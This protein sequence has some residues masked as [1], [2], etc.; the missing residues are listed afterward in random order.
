MFLA[1]DINKS[2]IRDQSDLCGQKIY[3][4]GAGFGVNKEKRGLDFSGN[5]L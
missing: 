2:R 4:W 1:P 5:G 3:L